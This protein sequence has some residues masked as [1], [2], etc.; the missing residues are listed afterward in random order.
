MIRCMV[1]GVIR[2]L[3]TSTIKVFN[4]VSPDIFYPVY[5]SALWRPEQELDLRMFT[6]PLSDNAS[7]VDRGPILNET[8]WLLAIVLLDSWKKL[9]LQN[10][11]TFFIH[12]TTIYLDKRSST[13]NKWKTSLKRTS[14]SATSVV[15]LDMFYV[16]S[17][18]LYSVN[19]TRPHSSDL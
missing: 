4:N 18:P 2:I 15:N 9:I 10:L 1:E 7:S 16:E 14:F 13:T 11:E 5:V 3:S 19:K 6:K 8:N 17:G 12:I